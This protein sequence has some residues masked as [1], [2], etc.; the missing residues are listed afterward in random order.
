MLGG[1][2]G[3]HGGE[4]AGEHGHQTV[5]G[6][7]DDGSIR[8]GNGG[9]EEDVVPREGVLHLPRVLFPETRAALDVREQEGQRRIADRRLATWRLAEHDSRRRLDRSPRDRSSGW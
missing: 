4:R 1:D 5:A 9:P 2:R 8:I 3:S 7:L 6:R